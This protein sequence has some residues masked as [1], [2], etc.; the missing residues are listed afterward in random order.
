MVLD[1]AFDCWSQGKTS[2]DYH[3]IYTDWHEP[4]RRDRNHPSVIA[5]SIGNEIPEQSSSQGGT[6]GK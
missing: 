3:L 6:E 2:N 4:D 5:W 1:E